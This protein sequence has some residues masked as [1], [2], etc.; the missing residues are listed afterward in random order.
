MSTVTSTLK[1]FDAM[2]GPLKNITQGMNMMISTMQ[3]MQNVTERNTNID[4]MLLG[5]KNKIA[6]AELEINRA[7]RDAT[8]QQQ[9][10]NNKVNE[11]ARHTDRLGSSLK[12]ILGTYLSIQGLKGL[13]GKM[14]DAV[15]YASEGSTSE[16]KLAQVLNTRMGMDTRQIQQF[17]G[18]L[19]KM[20][21]TGAVSYDALV[22]GA[23]EMATYMT[24]SKALMSTLNTLSN[25]TAAQYGT[26]T[27]PEQF[28]NLA[29]GAGRVYSGQP[30]GLS[31]QGWALDDSDVKIFKLGNDTQK[32]AAFAALAADSYGDMNKVI[33]ATPGG[34]MRQL[35]E[36]MNEVS[37]SLGNNLLPSFM[38]ATQEITAMLTD[39][40][41]TGKID[42]FFA[43]IGNAIGVGVSLVADVIQVATNFIVENM[44]WIKSALISVSV[45]FAGV[46][47]S[48]MIGWI[49]AAWPI[50]L[51]IGGLTAVVYG[52]TKMGVTADQIIG[53][54]GGL[55]S[56][57]GANIYNMVAFIH[58][59]FADFAEFFA[60]V[61]NHPVYTVKRLF[62]NFANTVLDLV[63]QVANAID[64]VFGSNLAGSLT[65]LSDKMNN[66]LGEMPEGYKVMDRMVMK[67]LTESAKSGYQFGENIVSGM[68]NLLDGFKGMPNFAKGAG[69]DD[70][71]GI[72]DKVNKVGKIEDKVDISSEDL[73]TMRELAEM[74]S[75]QNYVT[76]TPTVSFGDT[77]VRQESDIDEIMSRISVVLEEEIASSASRLYE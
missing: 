70:G 71:S 54:V 59:G 45:V 72:I 32:A 24:D 11:G 52:L 6:S 25:M 8:E 73:K 16:T 7:I 46:A 60:N 28:Y 5:A 63:S 39:M 66:W 38:L 29:T 4:K 31:R 36:L 2:T 50:F 13:F 10:F 41:D 14:T 56:V 9:K 58:N 65:S 35:N 61:F 74:K 37:V 68:G 48:W 43:G 75:I 76:L 17:T 77:H 30:G 21:R 23:S 19:K 1:M 64:A 53:F 34:K 33:A 18:E 26:N 51:I 20:G 69:V 42:A 62:V 49:A 15:M 44:D 47:A 57:L 12:G 27:T 22:E 55:F 40:L 3:T 67:D